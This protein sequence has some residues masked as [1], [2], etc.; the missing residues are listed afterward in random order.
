MIW[1][2]GYCTR[3][4]EAVVAPPFRATTLDGILIDETFAGILMG[5]FDP[6]AQ[7]ELGIWRRLLEEADL[8]VDCL[9]VLIL[10]SLGPKAEAAVRAMVPQSQWHGFAIAR[11]TDEWIDLIQPDRPERSFAAMIRG[12]ILNPLM[13]G[14]PTEEA[15]DRFKERLSG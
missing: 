14:I 4:L 9:T 12:G 15:W 5:G 8:G 2:V 3:E 7:S 6:R 11:C 1:R 10:E 13:I